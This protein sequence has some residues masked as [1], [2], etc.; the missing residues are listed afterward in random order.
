MPPKKSKEKVALPGI[1]PSNQG[2]MGAVF[3][4]FA[5]AL[6]THSSPEGANEEAS[7]TAG[8]AAEQLPAKKMRPTPAN[9]LVF[10][11]DIR[12]TGQQAAQLRQASRL[13]DACADNWEASR[14]LQGLVT[15]ARN[16]LKDD[17]ENVSDEAAVKHCLKR[18]LRDT[19]FAYRQVQWDRMPDVEALMVAARG[20]LAIEDEAAKAPEDLEAKLA[21]LEAG[22]TNA[23]AALTSALVKH[24]GQDVYS[25]R[26]GMG[27]TAGDMA[28]SIPG[29]GEIAALQQKHQ[30]ALS[31]LVETQA[32]SSA[33]TS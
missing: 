9:F 10:P 14:A 29:D 28:K 31:A 19:K 6:V 8:A 3:L 7:A 4:S 25:K 26:V 13:L 18:G 33:S 21:S 1:T 2:E 16:Q 23:L 30:A 15:L 20:P 17:D 27:I 5:S 32:A 22:A 24:L 12:I 11:G